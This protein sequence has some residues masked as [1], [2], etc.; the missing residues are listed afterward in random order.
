MTNDLKSSLS[1]FA[2]ELIGSMFLTMFFTSL[3]QSVILGSLTV[4]TIFTWKIT[5]SHFNPAITLAYMLKKNDRMPVLLG[6]FYIVSQ[7]LGAYVGALI[8]NFY[9]LD[10][11]VLTFWDDF[12]VRSFVNELLGSF[13]FV[14]FV[15][16]Q[17]DEKLSMTKHATLHC[18]GIASSYVAARAIFAGQTHGTTSSH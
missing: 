1:K 16:I 15:L 2:F 13:F 3:D 8:V 4:L 9:T 12:F 14:I 11:Q 10:L 5:K 7:I 18:F 17:I 6:I